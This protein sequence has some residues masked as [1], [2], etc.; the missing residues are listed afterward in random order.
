ME[1]VRPEWRWLSW[2]ADAVGGLMGVGAP[3]AASMV[4]GQSRRGPGIQLDVIR[5]LAARRRL[6]NSGPQR[7]QSPSGSFSGPG[8]QGQGPEFSGYLSG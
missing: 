2:G 1:E 7:Q 6:A 5:E 3:P 4:G 8:D